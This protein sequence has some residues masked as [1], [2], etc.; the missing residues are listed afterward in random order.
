MVWMCVQLQAWSAQMM[1]VWLLWLVVSIV[2]NRIH[3]VTLKQGELK[4]RSG[5]LYRRFTA[6]KEKGV[7][8]LRAPSFSS[9]I[10]FL[11]YILADAKDSCR[12]E[13]AQRSVLFRKPLRLRR[14]KVA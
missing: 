1:N 6:Q 10:N 4:F 11:I 2:L 12:R 3:H 7:V 5:L 9:F 8:R 13:T 14:Q